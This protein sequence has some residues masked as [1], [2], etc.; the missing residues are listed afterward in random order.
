M[1]TGRFKWFGGFN[2]TTNKVNDYG[3]IE[4]I[5]PEHQESVFV[6]LNNLSQELRQA[7][8][9]NRS[10]GIYVNFDVEKD[11]KGNFAVNVEMMKLVG[12]VDWFAKGIGYVKCENRDDVRITADNL[13][14]C[15]P[16]DIYKAQ[17]VSLG[18]SYN[19]FNKK[20]EGITVQKLGDD[21]DN[22]EL[23]TLCV[24]SKNPLIFSKFLL[25]TFTIYNP[26]EAYALIDEKITSLPIHQQNSLA[27][28]ITHKYPDIFLHSC[29]IRNLLPIQEHLSL[30]D[31]YLPTIN[32]TEGGIL[33]DEVLNRLIHHSDIAPTIT[34]IYILRQGALSHEPSIFKLFLLKYIAS[35]SAEEA[36]KLVLDKLELLDEER[37]LNFLLHQ[38][39][40]QHKH[41]FLLSSQLRGWL[42]SHDSNIGKYCDL[43]NEHLEVVEDGL[44]QE[45]IQEIL[46]QIT[47]VEDDRKNLLWDRIEYLSN[48]LTYRGYL[49]D[50]APL[51][52][53]QK[54]IQK[55][56]KEFF[57]LQSEFDTSSYHY[58]DNISLETN[59]LF[60]LDE[61]SEKLIVKWNNGVKNSTDYRL[62]SARGAE[63]L[64]MEF[65]RKLGH[66]VEDISIHQVTE[67]SQDWIKGDIRVDSKVLLDVKN[68]RISVNSNVYSEF[69]IPNFKKERTDD[70]LIVGVLSPLFAQEKYNTSWS[71]HIINRN[72]DNNHLARA[73]SRKKIITSPLVLGTF[74]KTKLEEL[75]SHF[76]DRLLSI[77]MGRN[78]STNNYL[79]HWV[80]DYPEDFYIQ[81]L[82]SVQ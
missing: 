51:K 27:E 9:S 21:T 63:K 15:N 48:H 57:E 60:P 12:V 67:K 36:I 66:Q 75:E 29:L 26:K 44:Q 19:S 81:Q 61:Q 46:V 38:L 64:V 65:Y 25:H 80:F 13:V 16:E 24:T 50:L 28:D 79:P 14:D 40:S 78:F 77:N 69:C 53:Q 73:Y 52:Y 4:V 43:I 30:L 11:S 17:V 33:I 39:V 18:I 6:H 20:H 3:F 5:D 42:L 49:W 47:E 37:E 34:N 45:L 59:Q 56:F 62:I 82:V 2:K 22:I 35:L 7:L 71:E 31:N 54:V 55:R 32:S 10:E 41:L 70:V 23:L 72:N 74:D 1:V 76:S 58:S 68:A 8:K